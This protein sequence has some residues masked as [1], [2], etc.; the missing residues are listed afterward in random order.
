MRAV[1]GEEHR[2]QG[3]SVEPSEVESRRLVRYFH[4]QTTE[5]DVNASV[6]GHVVWDC[7][8]WIKFLQCTAPVRR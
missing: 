4:L 6:T 8:L 7:D 3:D 1:F 2:F 5:P